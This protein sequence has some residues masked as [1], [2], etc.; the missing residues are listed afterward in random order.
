MTNMETQTKLTKAKRIWLTVIALIGLLTSIKLTVIFYESN[1]NPYALNSFCSIN[2]LI[3]CDGVAKTS[4]A[5][6]FGVPLAI[7]GL[8]LYSFILFMT[9]VDKLKKIKF[10]TFLEVFKNPPSYIFAIGILAFFI[11]M[12]LAFISIYEIKKICILCFFTY[13][14]N[15]V[16][17]IIAAFRT[18]KLDDLF[19]DCFRDFFDAVKVKKYLIAFLCVVTA[20]VGLWVY[21]AK[22]FVLAPHMKRVSEFEKIRHMKSNPYKVSGNVLGDPN[23]KVVVYIYSDFQCPACTMFNIIIHRVAHDLKNVRIVHK[24]FPLDNNCNKMM[25]LQMHPGS[26]LLAKYAIAAGYQN[27]YWDMSDLLFDKKPKNEI[28]LLEYAKKSGFDVERLQSDAK[29]EAVASQLQAELELA[30]KNKL[31]ATPVLQLGLRLYPGLTPYSELEKILL[32][33]GAQKR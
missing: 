7:W 21:V 19:I 27:K 2:S 33:A 11:S 4:H 1:Y 32:E 15:L 16:I 6:F 24:N 3:D 22:S 23:G 17:A 5:V 13:I 28:E 20:G 25:K 8:I 18:K 12:T 26:C 30:N 29:S 9:Y 10:L 31:N 14:L